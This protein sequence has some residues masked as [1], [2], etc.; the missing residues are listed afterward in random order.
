MPPPSP[1]VASW[2]LG[3]RL[4]Q[5][6]V[7]LG[8]E[9]KT[10]TD[11]LG[12]SRNYWSAVENKRKILAA[13]Q[14]QRVLDLLEYDD[15]ERAELTVLREAARQRGWWSAYSALF[16][17]ELLRL[18]GLE[19]GAQS[20]R[21]YDNLLIPGLLQTADYAR[22]L[23]VADI[24]VRPVEVDQRVAVRLRRQ[25]RLSGDDP[26]QLTAV[27]SQAALLQQIGGPR[28]LREQLLHLA[29][30]V[31]EHPDTIELRVIPFTTPACGVF[32]ASTF[33]LIDFASARLPTLA[34]LETVTAS[35]ALDED[36]QVR[37]L[38]FTYAEALQHSL[39]T[40]DSL[41]LVNESVGK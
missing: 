6:R 3:L 34:W 11:R 40:E 39:S 12:F 19:H 14:L 18:Y 35:G 7:Q 1:T 24:S 23:M 33:Y 31:A 8:V 41:R 26:L 22:A 4:R 16:S 21:T 20:I 9:V 28:V 30:V 29:A 10:I 37:E 13:E 38:H 32:G 27:I 25:E 17:D 2:E 15:E 5:R 36:T